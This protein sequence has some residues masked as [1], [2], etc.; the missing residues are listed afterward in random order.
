MKPITTCIIPFYNEGKRTLDVLK[1]MVQVKELD[2]IICVDDGST[3]NISNVIRNKYKKVTVL[4]LPQNKGKTEAINNGVQ[5]AK[6]KNIILIDA[7]LRNLQ[8]GYI[9]NAVIKMQ[10][11]TRVDMII[12]RR[13]NAPLF[14]R[15]IRGDILVS[16]ERI[17]RKS[18][19]QKALFSLKPKGYQ[20]EFA[21][22]QYMLVNHKNVYWMRSSALN[23]YPPT[24]MGLVKGLKKIIR[25]N[26]NILNYIGFVNYIKQ[27]IFFCR[28][29]ATL[30]T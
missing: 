29:E 5:K 28:K 2:E 26:A 16:G 7:D 25:M 23:T 17:L 3:D 18:D 12:L 27:L 13:A 11:N 10:H 14:M 9:R 21:V 15:V 6:G 20:L 24:K 1:V 4:V 19:L 30:S 22:N 8:P